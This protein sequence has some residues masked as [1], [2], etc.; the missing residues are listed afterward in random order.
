MITEQIK[1][2]HLEGGFWTAIMS[3]QVH[4]VVWIH[5]IV[6]NMAGYNN[7]I[8]HYNSEKMKYIHQDCWCLY[9]QLT[10]PLSQ[11]QLVTLADLAF[12][13]MTDGHL[14]HLYKKNIL[15]AFDGIPL[16]NVDHG[17]MNCIPTEGFTWVRLA[18]LNIFLLA[19]VTWLDPK[20]TKRRRW[21]NLMIC[22]GAWWKQHNIRVNVI[23]HECLFKID[24]WWNQYVH[25][26]TCW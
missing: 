14:K 22:I 7:R 24:N 10:D 9:E 15:N 2:I 3:W 18:S 4:V 8:G 26:R 12:A 19:Y 5:F 17:L 20:N 21:S 1:K 23:I 11:C 6:G 25:L 13:Q 16:S